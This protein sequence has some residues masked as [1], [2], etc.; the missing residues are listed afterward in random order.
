MQRDMTYHTDIP[1]MKGNGQQYVGFM[2]VGN[3]PISNVWTTTELIMQ[4]IDKYPKTY[5]R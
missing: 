5:C 4:Q 2:I 1:R 3:G